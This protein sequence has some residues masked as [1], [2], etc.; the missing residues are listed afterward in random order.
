MEAERVRTESAVLEEQIKEKESAAAVLESTVAHNREN[1]DRAQTELA[2]A[3]S[4]SGG[5][6]GRR[7]SRRPGWRRSTAGSGS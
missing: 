4:R 7:R 3:E 5:W 1:I 2:E 6:P